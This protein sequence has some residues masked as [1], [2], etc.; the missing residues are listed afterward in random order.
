MNFSTLP[1]W[2]KV[3]VGAAGAFAVVGGTVGLTAAVVGTSVNGTS[4]APSATPYTPAPATS[5]PSPTPSPNPAARAVALAVLDAEAQV[6]GIQPAQLRADFRA[7]TTVQTLAAR[8]GIAETQFEAQLT[9]DLKPILD[10]DVQQGS[11][12]SAQEQLV[13]RRV[14]RV[15]PNWDHV[16]AARQQPTQSPSP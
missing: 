5:T 13:L 15:I 10:L 12:T 14:G 8:N 3:A 1:A 7:G 4:A 16:G 9:A 2:S 6:L 11:I